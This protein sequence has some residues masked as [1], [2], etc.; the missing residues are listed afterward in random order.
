MNHRISNKMFFFFL[1]SI[2]VLLIF[3]KH[4]TFFVWFTEF[5][6]LLV[7]WTFD[8]IRQMLGPTSY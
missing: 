2:T 3:I 6:F 4:Y 1:K 7:V 8:L 5:R